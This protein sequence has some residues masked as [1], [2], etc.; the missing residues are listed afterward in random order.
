MATEKSEKSEKSDL[1]FY[2]EKCDYICYRKYDFSKHILTLKHEKLQKSTEKSEKSENIF[3]CLNCDKIFKDR[4]GLWR[5]KKKCEKI[6]NITPEIIL[7]VIQQN[8]EFKDML[9]EQNKQNQELQKQNSELQKQML[10]VHSGY[11][12]KICEYDCSKKYNFDRHVLTAKHIKATKTIK[13]EEFEQNKIYMCN[14]CDKK[15]KDR[16]GLWRHKKTCVVVI[17]KNSE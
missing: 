5:H 17:D 14:N 16:A 11:F 3:T 1:N 15:Y 6:E 2:C 12:C 4:T 13:K 9:I 10:E 8:Q 7:N